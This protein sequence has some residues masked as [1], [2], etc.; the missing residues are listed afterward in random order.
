MLA[1]AF[2]P[3]LLKLILWPFHAAVS[4]FDLHP[5]STALLRTLRP[6]GAFVLS[7]KLAIGAGFTLSLP[8]VLWFLGKFVLPG[9]TQR[10]KRYLLPSLGAGTL[11]FLTGMGFCYF[12]MLPTALGFFWTYG[13]KLG[14]ANEWTIE[15]YTAL[16]VQLLL[17]FGLV[18]ELPVVLLFLVKVGI[19]GPTALREK[20]KYVIVGIFI[21]AAAVTPTPD[22][23]SQIFLAV[24]MLLLYEICIWVAYAMERRGKK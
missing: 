4:R 22:V 13:E 19:V 21:V 23:I 15:Y 3:V 12:V 14:I 9:L 20:R 24:P 17:A 16:V 2:A 8:F 6:T 7:M 10:E 5:P 11:L 18:F 1:F